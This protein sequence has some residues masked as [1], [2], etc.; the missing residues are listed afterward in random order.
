MLAMEIAVASAPDIDPDTYANLQD[1][2]KG[3]E[4]TKVS[5]LLSL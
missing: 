2:T 1:S 5:N 3:S 4:G